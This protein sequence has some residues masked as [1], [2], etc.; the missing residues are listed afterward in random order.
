MFQIGYFETV[1]QLPNLWT[2]YHTLTYKFKV[3]IPST[4]PIHSKEKKKKPCLASWSSFT[5]SL[6]TLG[7]PFV[8]VGIEKFNSAAAG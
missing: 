8:S 1:K 5:L 4:Q 3:V 7:F 6:G 2:L